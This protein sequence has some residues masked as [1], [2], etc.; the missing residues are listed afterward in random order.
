MLS[1]TPVVSY[2]ASYPRAVEAGDFNQDGY[3]DLVTAGNDANVGVLL[4]Q[5]DGTFANSVGYPHQGNAAYEVLVGDLNADGQLDL[6][7]S[8]TTSRITGYYYGYYGGSYPIYTNDGHVKVLLGNGDGS[9]TPGATR[10]LGELTPTSMAHGDLDNDGDL[11]LVVGGAGVNGGTRVLLGN[12]DGTFAAPQSISSA[13]FSALN[14]ADLNDD[15]KLDLLALTGGVAVDLLLGNGDGTFQSAQRVSTG[16]YSSQAVGDVNDDGKL[17]LVAGYSLAYWGYYYYSLQ[18]YA[19]VILGKGDGTFGGGTTHLLDQSYSSRLALA[20]FSGDG[21]L[22]LV[23]VSLYSGSVNLL[24]ND[25]NGTLGPY[26]AYSTNVASGAPYDL[27]VADLN[28]DATLDL[29]IANPSYGSVAVLLEGD[30]PPFVPLITIG[31]ATLTEGNSGTQNA[32]F[33]VTLSGASATPVA[34]AYLTSGDTAVANDDYLTASGTLTFAPGETSKL[35]TVPVTGDTKA[36]ANETFFVNLSAPSGATI[37]DGQGLGTILD[38]DPSVS[39]SDVTRFEGNSGNTRFV[40]TVSL[41]AA[42]NAPVVVSYA[43]EDGTAR[44]R[45]NDYVAK[46]GKLTFAPGETSQTIT[47]QVKG[48]R[49]NEANES[50]FVNLTKVKGAVLADSQGEGTILDDD[51]SRL[52]HVWHLLF[53]AAVDDAIDDFLDSRPKKGGK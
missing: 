31:D 40:F 36:E 45:D 49:K 4:N 52:A 8:T 34:V 41:S 32:I 30:P 43:T 33:T 29:A 50:F 20:D 7:V 24:L 15:G 51:R 39:I 38:D 13:R 5:G 2:A 10:D 44:K 37:A 12:G 21:A 42:S 18:G 22:D 23:S 1:F 48:D 11:D 35:V 14:L 47:V 3:A 26:T 6:A 9:F 28:G 17:D 53:W 19:A 27:A 46:S 16:P 25:G